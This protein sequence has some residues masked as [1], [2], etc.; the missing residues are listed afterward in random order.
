MEIKPTGATT[1]EKNTFSHHVTTESWKCFLAFIWS[2][3]PSVFPVVLRFHPH[4]LGGKAENWM[5]SIS[6]DRTSGSNWGEGGLVNHP[7]PLPILEGCQGFKSS[8]CHVTRNFL[9]DDQETIRIGH[10]WRVDNSYVVHSPI[11]CRDPVLLNVVCRDAKYQTWD[12]LRTNSM[13]YLWTR[14]L[15]L[16][17]F[18]NSKGTRGSI[19]AR[20]GRD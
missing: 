16:G 7:D 10:S 13:L 17:D 18:W 6:R 4:Q 11:Q 15:P 5:G 19:W 20:D 1:M 2:N 3:L 14:A 12:L 9:Q 8:I